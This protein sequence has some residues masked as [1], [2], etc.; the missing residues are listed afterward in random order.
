[1][2]VF[3]PFQT[4]KLQLSCEGKEKAEFTRFYYVTVRKRV[5]V[6]RDGRTHWETRHV[7]EERSER[8]KKKVTQMD[9]KVDLMDM[10]AYDYVIQ[11]GNYT[12]GFSFTLPKALSSTMD[13]KSSAIRNRPEVEVKHAIKIKLLGGAQEAKSKTTITVRQLPMAIDPSHMGKHLEAPIT[14][15]C[16]FSQGKLQMDAH[17]MGAFYDKTERAV[18]HAKVMNEACQADI[19]KIEIQLKHV[20]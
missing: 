18:C 20:V 6:H 12:A 7:R 5:R 10:A 17:F 15:C 11:P 3:S 16:C 4:R 8:M 2:Q 1:M 14:K 13:W 19:Q 9:F